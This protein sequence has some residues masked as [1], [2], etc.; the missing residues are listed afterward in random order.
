MKLFFVFL[1]SL[2]TSICSEVFV[3]DNPL[4]RVDHENIGITSFDIYEDE[5]FLLHNDGYILKEDS[6]IILSEKYIEHFCITQDGI[7]YIT[8]SNRLI[9]GEDSYE[10]PEEIKFIKDIR[11]I[12][13]QI[14][15]TDHRG[16]SWN[17][18]YNSIVFGYPTKD[19]CFYSTEK[20]S[21]KL[22]L[23]FNHTQ[24]K[25]IA[26]E[27]Y[28]NQILLSIDFL[29][30]MNNFYYIVCEFN[31]HNNI[32]RNVLKVDNIGNYEVLCNLPSQFLYTTKDIILTNNNIYFLHTQE[33]S[34]KIYSSENLNNLNSIN[35]ILKIN[36]ENN[37]DIGDPA[38]IT[39][40]QVMLTAESYEQH[41]WNAQSGN[42]TGGLIQDPMGLWIR[43]PSW[44]TV[45]AHTKIPYKWGGFSTIIGFDNGLSNSLYAGDNY[46]SKPYGSSYCIGVDCSGFVSRCWGLSSHHGS[47]LL[48]TVSTLLSSYEDLQRGDIL[49]KS[50]HVRL[51]AEDNPTGLVN[52]IEASGV[53]WRVSYRTYTFSS[54]TSSG[55]DP[56]YY[57][58]IEDIYTPSFVVKSTTTL[59]VREGPSVSNNIIT[60]ISTDQEFVSSNYT[61]NG[62]YNIYI[63]S[64]TGYSSGWCFGGDG[65]TTGYLTGDPY[66][67]KIKVKNFKGTLNVREGPSTSYPVITTIT[68]NQEFAVI[69]SQA[70]WYNIHLP[71]NTN[72]TTGWCSAGNTGQY[73][74][75]IYPGDDSLGFYDAEICVLEFPNSMQINSY[76]S[77]YI[78]I[79]NTGNFVYDSFVYIGTT[80]P[81]DRNSDFYHFSWITNNRAAKP[82]SNAL[83]NQKTFFKFYIEA[84]VVS[85]DSNFY[86]YFSLVK[87]MT[88]WFSDEGEITDTS[89]LLNILV[90]T[91]AYIE[92]NLFSFNF[93]EVINNNFQFSLN[94]NK[95]SFVSI[96]IYDISGRNIKNLI[97][98]EYNQGF[99]NI[100]YCFTDNNNNKICAG[101]YFIRLQ[102]D[103]ENRIYK[104]NYLE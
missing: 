92:E 58:N 48:P 38:E 12:N 52:T 6:K 57:N 39:R 21:N 81:R 68:T 25:V 80:Q 78:E 20:V 54:L 71:A 59:N 36:F 37:P 70:Q 27:F 95:P 51:C 99:Y 63:P 103:N 19:D 93:P 3:Y 45:G 2:S 102:I 5:I 66:I 10:I 30:T 94:L 47:S 8:P 60:T 89:I 98:R 22:G 74:E 55:Y 29:G 53:D 46:T 42:I 32:T 49:L 91:G 87:G 90:Q 101:I 72:F 85:N 62:W 43:T 88:R 61:T 76:D 79:K 40:D 96:K 75:I 65:L 13:D 56:R 77:C 11:D 83:P 41:N 67:T 34:L 7:I 14:W 64:G 24:E 9:V 50:G 44:V 23:I 4:Y 28:E 31:E 86:E 33:D 97:N 73:L 84:P 82:Y 17:Y 104:L 100:N 15:V 18:K 35:N 16:W 69:D 1:F 26:C